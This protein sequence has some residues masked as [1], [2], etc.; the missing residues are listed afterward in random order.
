MA[1]VS[2]IY[3]V[4][5]PYGNGDILAEEVHMSWLGTLSFKH[6]GKTVAFF[7]RGQWFQW[8]DKAHSHKGEA[9]K[10]QEDKPG[11]APPAK[12]FQP[13]ERPVV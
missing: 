9:A 6:Q 3:T 12:R 11:E 13:R 7:L 2:R 8:W 10:P 4:L 1:V 5:T